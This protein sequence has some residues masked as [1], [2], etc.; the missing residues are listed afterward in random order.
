VTKFQR[1]L[2]VI[3]MLIKRKI[4]V[5]LTILL[6]LFSCVT[7]RKKQNN[8]VAV[9]TKL[10]EGYFLYEANVPEKCFAR[11]DQIEQ[12]NNLIFFD[13]LVNE[14]G[15]E[16][17]YQKGVFVFQYQPMLEKVVDSGKV[18]TDQNREP[19]NQF[20]KAISYILHNE[21]YQYNNTYYYDSS[22]VL[23]YK[24]IYAQ[25]RV[26][27]CG[28]INQLVPHMG[29]YEC[30]YSNEIEAIETYFISDVMQFKLY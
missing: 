4:F 13:T 5:T 2:I 14:V 3:P 18:K 26:V 29:N 8:A 17:L 6:S 21:E 12:G 7:S 10:I 30:C 1:P 23:T 16:Q 24:K 19:L 9:T 20:E 15:I 22:K 28:K 25:F 11:F 27:N